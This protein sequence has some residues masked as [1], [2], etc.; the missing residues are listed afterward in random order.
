MIAARFR[1]NEPGQPLVGDIDVTD[2]RLVD[3]PLLA[4]IISIAGVTGIL[5]ALQGEGIGFGRLLTTFRLNDGL[6]EF[7]E[8]RMVGPSLGITFDGSVDVDHQSGTDQYQ[9]VSPDLGVTPDDL[10]AA[11]LRMAADRCAPVAPQLQWL[12]DA[13]MEH[14]L[15][16]IARPLLVAANNVGA[17]AYGSNQPFVDMLGLNDRHIARAPGKELG[18]PA[19]ESHDGSYV[20]DREPD[21]IFYG[22]PRLYVEPVSPQ[23][24][25]EA[26][27]PSDD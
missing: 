23:R 6:I 1:D 25:I 13:G 22:M 8:G 7:R 11:D 14:G 19:H 10:A 18:I 3:A 21:L 5:D 26:G 24:A 12:R 4:R 9:W 20:L 2:F 17:V 27:Y 15:N 16:M